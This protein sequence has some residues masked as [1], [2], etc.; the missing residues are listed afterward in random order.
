M[1]RQGLIKK[2]SEI[3]RFTVFNLIFWPIP[4]FK[5]LRIKEAQHNRVAMSINLSLIALIV[6]IISFVFLK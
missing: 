2:K 1:Q 4:V 3:I 6:L 5:F